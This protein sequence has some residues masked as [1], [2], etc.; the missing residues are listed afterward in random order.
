MVTASP[1]AVAIKDGEQSITY[2]ELWSAAHRV[3]QQVAHAGI[4]PGELVGIRMQ[5]GWNMYAAMLGVWQHNC[6]YVPIDPSYP[7]HRQEYIISDSGIRVVVDDSLDSP[8]FRLSMV[9][10]DNGVRPTVFPDAAYVIYTSGSTGHPKGVVLPH[11]SVLEFLSGFIQHFSFESSDVWAQFTSACF[12]VSVAEI[13]T[14]LVTGARLAVVSHEEAVNPDRLLHRLRDC[15]ATVLSQVPTVFRYL[16]HAAERSR[17]RLPALRRILLAGEPIELWAVA[18]WFELGVSPAAKVHNL[19]GPT[20]GTVY[21]TCQSLTSEL[22]ADDCGPGTPIGA[23][24][25]HVR[26]ELWSDGRPVLPGEVGEIHL[27]GALAT[28]YLGK[29]E[30]TDFAFVVGAD[31]GVRYRTGDLAVRDGDGQLRF[32]GRKDAQVK[33]RGMRIEL[34]EIEYQLSCW[35]EVAQAAAVM[36]PSRQGDPLIAAFYVPVDTA[37]GDLAG[38]LRA[39]LSQHLPPYMVPAKFVPLPRLPLTPSGKLDRRRLTLIAGPN[40]AAEL[41][42][43]AV[44]T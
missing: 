43:D 11:A 32:I 39:L 20:E 42:T 19:Y 6:G 33:L 16:L 13:W 24:M 4:T 31:G 2:A 41:T 5:R 29:K 30:L 27:R 22:L 38:R 25:P 35:P 15:D 18:R 8:G 1:A 28:G 23:G 7:Y 40:G 17:A 37:D 34:A 26:V 12:D 21:S 44:E 9:A 10:A 3:R 14:P 36:A